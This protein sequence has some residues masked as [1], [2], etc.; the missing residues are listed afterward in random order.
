MPAAFGLHKSMFLK[1]LDE[2]SS[3][4][5]R[6][7]FYKPAKAFETIGCYAQTELGHGSNI[8]GLETTAVYSTET[9][10]FTLQSPGLSSAKF[11]IGGLGRTADVAVVMA[12]LYTPDGKDGKLVH[13]G[14]HPFY[15]ELRD[16]VTREC[17]PGRTIMDLGPKAG[18]AAT[19]NGFMLLDKV[20]IPHIS[21]FARFSQVDKHTGAYTKPANQRLSCES[22]L[23]FWSV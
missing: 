2:Q 17:L 13:R 10:T 23:F 9:Q 4:E 6:E 7:L 3:E 20:E 18:Y 16:K 12:Q 21:L 15:V 8:Q 1:T 14:L 19:D 22:P 11:W 5:Q